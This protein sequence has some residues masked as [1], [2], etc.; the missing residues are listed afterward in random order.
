MEPSSYFERNITKP[1]PGSLDAMSPASPPVVPRTS[2]LS[3][4]T[5]IDRDD[6]HWTTQ[7]FSTSGNS[8]GVSNDSKSRAVSSV[9]SKFYD[10]SMGGHC[11][12]NPRPQYTRFSDIKHTG[13][14]SGRNGVGISNN[15]GDHGMGRCYSEWIDDGQTPVYFRMGVPEFSSLDKF[16]QNFSNPRLVSLATT[17]TVPYQL[18]GILAQGVAVMIGMAVKAPVIKTLMLTSFAINRLALFS[19]NKSRF[20][21]L[22][23]MMARYWSAVNVMVNVLMINEG[24]IPKENNHDKDKKYGI[25]GDQLAHLRK[26]MPHVFTVGNAI[27]VSSIV[28][29]TQRQT[30][31]FMEKEYGTLNGGSA[32][33]YVDH[34]S[35]ESKPMAP[36]SKN[37]QGNGYVYDQISRETGRYWFPNP[38]ETIGS[39][40]S[41]ARKFYE[42][43]TNTNEELHASRLTKDELRHTKKGYQVGTGV[44]LIDDAGDGPTVYSQIWSYYKAEF[45]DGTGF[46]CLQFDHIASVT[47]SFSNSTRESMLAEKYNSASSGI[48]QLKY[49]F[50]GGNIGSGPVSALVEASASAVTGFMKEGAELASAVSFGITGAVSDMFAGANMI[51]PKAWESSSA[52]F[53]QIEYKTTLTS[54]SQHP[55]ARLQNIYI[56]LSMMFAMAMPLKSGKQSYSNPFT[57]SV[58]HRGMSHIELGMVTSL[59]VERGGATNM[60]YDINRRPTSFTVSMTVSNLDTAM[61]VTIGA[62]ED[63][64][65][66]EINRALVN[67]DSFSDY[68]AA[69]SGIGMEEQLYNVPA[70]QRQARLKMHGF[71]MAWSQGLNA[72]HTHQWMRTGAA[73][74]I[75]A[76]LATVLGAVSSQKVS[77]AR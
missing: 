66:K 5:G 17:A 12:A 21:T 67:D 52:E 29:R 46:A 16:L 65:V 63:A 73:R 18:G 3:K 13:I 7:T 36:I 11:T 4:T 33:T 76:P 47:D 42:D 59:T 2:L 39:F 49:S 19:N 23:P 31:R 77:I 25:E 75:T 45:A 44:N 64:S 32:Q 43:K 57:V 48:R 8:Y 74:H 61:P 69:I 60:Q 37:V 14:M 34:H 27:D 54:P 41:K 6:S 20:Y 50:A 71:G 72:M 55:L 22:R 15:G 68:L 51:I 9:D 62:P 1:T 26:L 30:N 40:Y 38:G 58:W 56:P 70:A 28:S 24:F 35:G 10:T 53:P